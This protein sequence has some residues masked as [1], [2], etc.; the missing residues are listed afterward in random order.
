MA[1]IP[2]PAA[3]RRDTMLIGLPVIGF[4]TLFVTWLVLRLAAPHLHSSTRIRIALVLAVLLTFVGFRGARRLPAD[5]P[6]KRAGDTGLTGQ[7][8][9]QLR[10][11]HWYLL[12]RRQ[13][14]GGTLEDLV[15]GPG[16][17][18]HV[19][20]R[21]W[22]SDDRLRS[23]RDGRLL[24]GRAEVT[25]IAQAAYQSAD[26][27]ATALSNAFGRPVLVVP[28]MIATGR[29]APRGEVLVA[30]VTI[31]PAR[32]LPRWLL[33]QPT[34]HSV[35]EAGWLASVADQHLPVKA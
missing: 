30:G 25:H 29:G 1:R 22:D 28:V 14:P 17:I 31:L 21:A 9:P 11:R 24:Q 2:V 6:R 10:R 18:F 33:S 13:T 35:E 26:A 15:I 19:A 5:A 20:T 4:G 34:V 8:P 3:S 32:R 23:S 27:A 7:L 16:G 12:T